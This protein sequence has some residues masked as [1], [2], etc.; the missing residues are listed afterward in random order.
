MTVQVKLQYTDNWGWVSEQVEHHNQRITLSLLLVTEINPNLDRS[1]KWRMTLPTHNRT[2][3]EWRNGGEMKLFLFAVNHDW[4]VC[5]SWG[6]FLVIC[7]KM[8]LCTHQ[9][10]GKYKNHAS[11][12]PGRLLMALCYYSQR[13]KATHGK[14]FNLLLPIPFVPSPGVGGERA[15]L[16]FVCG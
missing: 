11:G 16:P 8:N 5:P 15:S 10:D 6:K 4:A 2:A 7:E 12:V 14:I 1:L 3:R 13:E 9:G